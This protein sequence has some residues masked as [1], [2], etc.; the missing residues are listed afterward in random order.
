M[1]AC[2]FTYQLI[3]KLLHESMSSVESIQKGE[4]TH[5]P[6]YTNVLKIYEQQTI[7]LGLYSGLIFFFLHSV[8]F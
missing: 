6:V 8:S 1:I 3:H 7:A 5:I 2:G 4:I